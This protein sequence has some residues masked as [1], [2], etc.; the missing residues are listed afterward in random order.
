MRRFSDQREPLAIQRSVELSHRQISHDFSPTIRRC[1]TNKSTQSLPS[2]VFSSASD[3]VDN[4]RFFYSFS[5]GAVRPVW[6]SNIESW[7]RTKNLNRSIS[8]GRSTSAYLLKSAIMAIPNPSTDREMS[9]AMHF[10]LNT[11]AIP[12][13]IMMNIGRRKVTKERRGSSMNEMFCFRYGRCQSIS[14]GC[15]WIWTL[16]GS[17]TFEQTRGNYGSMWVVHWTERQTR[18]DRRWIVF[19]GYTPNFTLQEDDIRAIQALYGK[20]TID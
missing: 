17:G 5:Y 16:V 7:K 3:V 13:L 14:S 10:S 9:S 11:E 6:S 2:I 19:K 15:T 8:I 4:A 1:W 20:R 12:I 18:A